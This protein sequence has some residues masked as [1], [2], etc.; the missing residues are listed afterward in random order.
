[1]MDQRRLEEGFLLYA[2]LEVPQK[3]DLK[4]DHIPCNRNEL[5]DLISPKFHDGFVQKWGG[6]WCHLEIIAV[7]LLVTFV[8]LHTWRLL[9][10]A[11]S[12]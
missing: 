3:H 9:V 12:G 10:L 7:G 1:M 11:Q 2:R 8:P 5:V 6:K 4:L